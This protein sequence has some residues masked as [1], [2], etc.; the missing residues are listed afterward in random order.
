MEGQ[1]G[2]MLVQTYTHTQTQV[3]TYTQKH[4]LKTHTESRQNPTIFL[5]ICQQQK[6]RQLGGVSLP[7]AMTTVKGLPPWPPLLPPL[8]L[9]KLLDSDVLLL[10][11]A[12]I[13][14][15]VCVCVCVCVVHVCVVN[16]CVCGACL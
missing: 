14:R 3:Q 1:Q 4:S 5:H 15:V 16:V 6:V 13:W 12:I 11:G 7:V 2:K 8:L 10:A 9:M